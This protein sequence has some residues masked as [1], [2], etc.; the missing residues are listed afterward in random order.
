MH[1]CNH[2]LQV[3]GR[4]DA[5]LDALEDFVSAGLQSGECVVVIA[6]RSHRDALITR[7]VAGGQD[8]AALI[9]ED[10]FIALPAQDTLDRFMVRGLPDE[11][12]FRSTIKPVIQRARAGGR[13][14]RAFGEMVALLWA[15][16]NHEATVEL[17]QLWNRFLGEEEIPLFCA[18]PSVG[19]SAKVSPH[20]HAIRAAHSH[21]VEG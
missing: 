15:R 11:A 4:Q 16:G 17:E 6:T 5:L 12:L 18:Y 3:Y 13:R 20:V 19:F 9:A 2:I 1:I 8:V 21:V 14:V 10:R 7:L